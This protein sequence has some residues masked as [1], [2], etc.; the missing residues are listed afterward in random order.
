MS[1][2]QHS[3]NDV[4]INPKTNRPIR[5]GGKVWLK[6]VKEGLV[7]DNYKDENI[8]DDLEND[9][10][11]LINEKI[12]QINKTLPPTQSAVKGRGKYKNKI[13][14]RNKKL[15]TK[16]ITKK[17]ANIASKTIMSNMELLSDV[18][19]NSD[20]IKTRMDELVENKDEEGIIEMLE[21][22]IMEEMINDYN[23]T[24]K[25]QLK[26]SINHDEY[27]E[28]E[29]DEYSDSVDEGEDEDEDEYEE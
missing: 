22:L 5:V 29:V 17:V 1:S 24:K 4:V 28:H 14:L 26:K 8:L 2:K 15:K 12:E 11:E 23:P 21:K 7:N 20:K 3:K 6:L 10:Y 25:P 16:D 19:K 18:N 9:E 27:E 13:V